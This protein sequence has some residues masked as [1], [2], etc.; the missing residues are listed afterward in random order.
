MDMGSMGE[1]GSS[2]RKQEQSV[3]HGQQIYNL[4]LLEEK[5]GALIYLSSIFT[6]VSPLGHPFSKESKCLE[7]G[8]WH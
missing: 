7:S 5:V 1:G 8:R 4:R 2:R 3:R 6:L